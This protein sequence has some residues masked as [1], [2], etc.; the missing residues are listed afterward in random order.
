[1]GCRQRVE[2][3]SLLRIVA[4]TDGERLLVDVRRRLPGRGAWLHHSVTCLDQA[5]KRRALPRA[6]RQPGPV[7]FSGV[8]LYV[9]S[10]LRGVHT[11]TTTDES[12]SY[13]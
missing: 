12:G 7:D 11:T 13:S 9:V 4:A 3:S 2:Q 6:L 8:R 10:C 1:M 5:E